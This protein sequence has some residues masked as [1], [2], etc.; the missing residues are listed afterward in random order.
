[1]LAGCPGVERASCWPGGNAGHA[2]NAGNA[3]QYP[4]GGLPGGEA[5]GS[6]WRRR[7]PGVSP[8][9]APRVTCCP[10]LPV[11][12][13]LAPD[14]ERQGGP[15]VAASTG[16]GGAASGRL[17]GAERPGR[18]AVGGDLGEG[19]GSR[20]GGVTDE[21]LRPGRALSPGDAGGRPGCA[22][23]SGGAAA[24][25]LFDRPTI[26]ALAAQLDLLLHG[27]KR[28][29]P[30]PPA[31]AAGAS[32]AAAGALLR[33]A[34]P[35]VRRPARAGRSDLQP[36]LGGALGGDLAVGRLR[37]VWS[38]LV[39]RHEALRTT[40]ADQARAR[41]RSSPR[42]GRYR[43]PWSPG[44]P[45][46]GGAGCRGPA[47]GAGGGPADLRPGGGTVAPADPPGLAAR[48][49][50]LLVTLHHVVAA[51]WSMG[52]MQR[53]M[54]L[55]Y[56]AFSRA[57]ARPAGAAGPVRRLRRL[58]R[59]WLAGDVLEEQ[60]AYWRRQLAARRSGWSCRSTGRDRSAQP[61]RGSAAG[62]A[63]RGAGAGG[64]GLFPAGGRDAFMTLL[65][66]F[67]CCWPAGESAEVWWR[68]DRQPRHVLLPGK[69]RDLLRQLPPAAPAADPRD[70]WG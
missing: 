69:G 30:S 62:A 12:G 43:C 53:E 56:G 67:G 61:S 70:G 54:A 18:E 27:A 35:L 5:G 38:E 47:P 60:L 50:V 10:R 49:H 65:A 1:V 68:A 4:A 26:A 45:A 7:R 42:P 28:R 46:G 21:L 33:P 14:A 2:G 63:G 8:G 66:A 64:R 9:D 22:R 59:G 40:F 52:V 6:G 58:Q 3:G 34:A 55:L 11:P 15:G 41:S 24:H 44:G 31:P 25:E 13:G 57:K 20:A 36:A 19:A 16:R 37:Q 39:R 29:G 51:S 48:Q 32:R 23:R 17:R